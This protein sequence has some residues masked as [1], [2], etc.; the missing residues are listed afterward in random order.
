MRD[1]SVYVGDIRSGLNNVGN[2]LDRLNDLFVGRKATLEGY[3]GVLIIKKFRISSG[4]M[5]LSLVV[6]VLDIDDELSDDE[7]Q[8]HWFEAPSDKIKLL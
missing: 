7:R 5:D 4:L 6:D 8:R 2:S 1:F 3:N